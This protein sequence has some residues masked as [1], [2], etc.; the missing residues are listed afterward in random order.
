MRRIAILLLYAFL[1]LW[2]LGVVAVMGAGI[3]GVIQGAASWGEAWGELARIHSPFN[4][5]FWLLV[6]I[7][8]LPAIGARALAE[9]LSRWASTE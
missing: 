4:W 1:W 9:R 8:V 7:A 3:I 6:L 5:L 2:L